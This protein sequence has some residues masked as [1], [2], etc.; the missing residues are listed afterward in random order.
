MKLD[1]IREQ[2]ARNG[3]DRKTLRQTWLDWLAGGCGDKHFDAGL[4]IMPKKVFYKRVP[5]NK[6]VGGN[7]IYR[8]LNR[9]ELEE[10]NKRFVALLNKQIYKEGYK[11]FG[12]KLDIVGVI[13]GERELIDLH[14]HMTIKMPTSMKTNEFARRVL[15]ALQLSGEFVIDNEKYNAKNDGVAERFCYKLD[16]IDSGWFSYIT[17]KLNGKDFDNLYLL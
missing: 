3:Y 1:E 10:A 7:N 5:N 2:L 12:K 15:K 9:G 6:G 16:I 13:E 11:R 4:T 8:H 17:K 14:T